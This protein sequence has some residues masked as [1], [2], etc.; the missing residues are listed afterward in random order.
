[1][2]ISILLR[3]FTMLSNGLRYQERLHFVVNFIEFPVKF[4][5]PLDSFHNQP[6]ELFNFVLLA[7]ESKCP[8]SR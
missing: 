8:R 4:L 5:D 1:M 7:L 6:D 2:L 3:P